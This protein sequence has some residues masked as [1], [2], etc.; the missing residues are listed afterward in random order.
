MAGNERQLDEEDGLRCKFIRR[1]G[2]DE[3]LRGLVGHGCLLTMEILTRF[4]C[5][6]GVQF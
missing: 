4:F 6:Y 1:C 2:T 5:T 3:R